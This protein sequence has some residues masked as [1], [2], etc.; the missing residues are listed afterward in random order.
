MGRFKNLLDELRL[1]GRVLGREKRAEELA[2]FFD[3][4]L[5]RI[6]NVVASI[7]ASERRPRVY[8]SFWGG[9]TKTP[10]FYEPVAAAGGINVAEGLLPAYAGTLIAVV[11]M[12]KIAAWDP[13]VI[14]IQG[15]YP[16]GQR[17]VT[18][19]SVLTDK[20]L[21]SLSAVRAGRVQYTF[22]FWNW[23]DPAQVLVETLLL[24]KAFHPD[25]FRDIDLPREGNAIFKAFYGLEA[26]FSALSRIL[27]CDEWSHG[28]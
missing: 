9:L 4:T 26:G 10:V 24:A 14:L 18:V 17:A 5:A 6:R 8:L 16:P 20:R 11:G 2:S 3:S 19:G 23:W 27:R 21:A 28:R 25:R 13:D 1:V 7:P 15:N 22:G 12:E